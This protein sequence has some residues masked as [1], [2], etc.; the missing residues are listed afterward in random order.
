MKK[1][2]H[3]LTL[4]ILSLIA[5]NLKSQSVSYSYVKNNPFDIKNF[6]AS[7][8]PLFIDINGNN[9]YAFGWGLRGEYMMGKRLLLNF[10][11]RIGFGTKD[12][13]KSNENTKNYFVMDGG[14]G[15]IFSNKAKN[16]HVRVILSQSTSGNVRTTTSISVPAKVRLICALRGGVTQYNNTLKYDGKGLADSL[17]TFTGG[18][19]TYTYKQAKADSGMVFKEV[20]TVTD[21]SVTTTTTKAIDQ[22][23]G[24][25]MVSIYGG[26]Q[27]RSIRDLLIDVDGYGYR[28]NS[29]Y[30]DFF[31][32]VLFAPIVKIKDF[33]NPDGRTYDVKYENV[34]HF[35]W[36]LGW[37]WR[38]PKDQGFSAKF[39]VGSRPGF[40]APSNTSIPV[41]GRNLYAMI[42]FGLYIPLNIKPVYHGEE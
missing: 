29:V 15:L 2:I 3:T 27:F 37:F 34:S 31:V 11:S 13:R 24:I 30:Q 6:S 36:R 19:H 32:D 23:G 1:I 9:G 5:I 16:K 20:H 40:K 39:E 42:S 35:G 21:G 12:Y 10:D 33:K 7:I 41:N 25:S 8:D 18:G 28:G 4:A 26:I 14:L 38:K 22:L 17:L